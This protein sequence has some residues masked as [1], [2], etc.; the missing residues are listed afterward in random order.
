M[1]LP[2]AEFLRRFL[3]HVLPS[4][5]HRIRHYGLLGNAH[6]KASLATA[7]ELLQLPNRSS[8]PTATK[9]HNAPQI[10]QPPVFLCRHC[11]APM[12]I[13]QTLLPTPHIRGPPQRLC[14]A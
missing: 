11:G 13:L 6:R 4:G 3:L 2:A 14:S 9:E 12:T 8:D 5:F 7:R 1:T 10:P